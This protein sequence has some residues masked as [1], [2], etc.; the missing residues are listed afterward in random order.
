MS[1]KFGEIR[2]WTTE[3]AAL[4]RLKNKSHRLIMEKMTSSHFLRFFHLSLFILAGNEDMHKSLAEFEIRPDPTTGFHGNRE[5]FNLE[6]GV[7]TFS[8]LFLMGSFSYLQAV[9]TYIRAW[10]S[11]KFDQIRPQ[12]TELAALK[13]LKN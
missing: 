1:S 5:C 11:L 12:T 13:R 8:R 10:M 4:E 6:S 3:L 2:P 9:M 7:A